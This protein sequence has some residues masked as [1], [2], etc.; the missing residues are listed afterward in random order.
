MPYFLRYVRCIKVLT[1][2]VAINL[3]FYYCIK[4]KT[5]EHYILLVSIYGLDTIAIKNKLKYIINMVLLNFIVYDA[6]M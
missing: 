3:Y 2:F 5:S 6:S 1:V 4:I